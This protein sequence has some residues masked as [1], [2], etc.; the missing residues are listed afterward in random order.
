MNTYATIAS[1]GICLAS[2][3]GSSG[4][5]RGKQTPVTAIDI[6]LEPNATIVH[7]AEAVNARLRS[8]FPNRMLSA[9]G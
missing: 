1:S 5:S 3:L 9:P 8:V 4:S 7:H 2:L 6:A